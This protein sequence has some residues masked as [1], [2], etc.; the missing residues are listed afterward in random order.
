MWAGADD[1]FVY[2]YHHYHYY[3]VASS[4]R[5]FKERLLFAIHLSP[6]R[7]QRLVEVQKRVG[8]QSFRLKRVSINVSVHYRPRTSPPRPFLD[9][10]FT[11]GTQLLFGRP[12]R[13][14]SSFPS[15]TPPHR[16]RASGPS[17]RGLGVLAIVRARFSCSPFPAAFIMSYIW[18]QGVRTSWQCYN[19]IISYRRIKD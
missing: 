6:G 1:V 7:R 5:S 15:L 11:L 17:S 14:R 16:K 2:Y 19:Y 18:Y 3:Y 13:L 9:V 8:Y 10:P 12:K 4:K